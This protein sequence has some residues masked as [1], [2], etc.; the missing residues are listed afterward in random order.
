MKNLK[1]FIE[2]INEAD[3]KTTLGIIGNKEL[4]RQSAQKNQSD[5]NKSTQNQTIQKKTQ[6]QAQLKI[7]E[8]D[9]SA[10][11]IENTHTDIKK[12]MDDTILKQDLLPT[13]PNAKKQFL[14]DTNQDLENIDK[15]L[16]NAEQQ[17]K[18]LL[19]QKKRIQKNYLGK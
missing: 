9:K 18:Y 3:A 2:F 19:D 12:Q 13:D 10:K 1:T 5:S 11:D 17:R 6:Q 15:N 8:L 7:S 16:T 4:D 14:S